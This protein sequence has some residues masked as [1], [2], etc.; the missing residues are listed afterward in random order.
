VIPLVGILYGAATVWIVRRFADGRAI[1]AAIKRIQAHLL[2]FWLYVDEP[3]TIWKSWKRLLAA[4][5]RLFGLLVIPF[6]I[7]AIPSVP[8]YF[9][10]DAHYGAPPLLV[11]KPAVV[12][13]SFEGPAGTVPELVAPDGIA[14][15]TP[16]VIVASLHEVSWRIRPLRALSGEL[17]WSSAGT[18]VS[19][20]ITAAERYPLAHWSVWFLGFSLAGAILGRYFFKPAA[21]RGRS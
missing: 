14:V 20:G 9:L 6:L 4:N 3:R 19:R 13:I 15:E 21:I 7:L 17:H 12:S 10:L 1:L 16:P 8:L 11:G 5:V 18:R 2:E